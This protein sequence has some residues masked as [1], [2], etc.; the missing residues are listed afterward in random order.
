MTP[1]SFRRIQELFD[2]VAG[3]PPEERRAL[4]DR[5][6]AGDAALRAEVASLL[7]AAPD[8]AVPA[9]AAVGVLGCRIGERFV[10]EALAGIGGMGTVYRAK[11]ERTGR[12]VALKLLLPSRNPQDTERFEREG[13]LLAE[14]RHPAI[15]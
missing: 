5:L 6:S 2:A 9:S 12:T 10:L 15:V 4:L 11:D 7:A 14:L 3:A 8:A 1:A 13:S